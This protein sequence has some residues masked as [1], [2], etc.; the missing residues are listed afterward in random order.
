MAQ[1]GAGSGRE[2]GVEVLRIGTR[3]ILGLADMPSTAFEFSNLADAAV[4][5]A[6]ELGLRDIAPAADSHPSFA[7]IA[8]LAVYLSGFNSKA[9][10]VKATPQHGAGNA[11]D[12]P[13]SPG[14]SS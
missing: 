13:T 14:S 11:I 9:L 3:D 1:G 4:Q 10:R 6:Y 12:K 2:D 8:L 7:V 5:K